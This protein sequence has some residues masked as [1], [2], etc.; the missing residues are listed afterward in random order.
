[1]ADDR[2]EPSPYTRLLKDPILKGGKPIRVEFTNLLDAQQQE[3]VRNELR[4]RLSYRRAC[5]SVSSSEVIVYGLRRVRESRP[6]KDY[7]IRFRNNLWPKP[8]RLRPPCG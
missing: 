1:M 5:F 6:V 3:E 7:L 2:R 8:I 4:Q